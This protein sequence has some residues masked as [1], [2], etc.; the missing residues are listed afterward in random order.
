MSQV[1][2]Q[3]SSSDSEGSGLTFVRPLPREQSAQSD[4]QRNQPV[5]LRDQLEFA[6]R[7]FPL[8]VQGDSGSLPPVAGLELGHFVLEERIGRGGMGAVFRAI[9]KRLDRVVALKIL[10]SELSTDPEA[11]QRFQ[12][13]AR[14][15]AKLDHD[16]IARVHYIG[17]E[18]GLHFIA[19]EFV[20]G[21]NVR[22][23]IR[24]KG[25]L[26]PECVVNYTLQIAEALRQ[27]SA[28]GVVHRDIKPS[29]IIISS[30]GCAKLVDL[31]LARQQP[32]DQSQD[33]TVA[34]TALGTFDYIAPEQ[35]MDARNVDVRSDIYSLGC[36][37]Y[38]MLTGEPPYPKGTMFQKVMNHHGPTPPDAQ[39]KNQSVTVQL[40]R[41]IQKMMASNPDE[42]HATAESLINDLVQIAE[43]LGLAP[44]SP[45]TVVWTTPLFKA[46]NPYWDGSRTWMAVALVLLLLVYLVDSL[47]PTGTNSVATS[48]PSEGSGLEESPVGTPESHLPVGQEIAPD[49]IANSGVNNSPE[50][51]NH[52]T[53][54]NR[55]SQ[56][57][58]PTNLVSP[59]EFSG[60]KWS[61]GAMLV[62]NESFWSQLEQFGQSGV[63]GEGD[64]SSTSTTGMRKTGQ[65][66]ETGT[67]FD[68]RDD[69]RP[70]YVAQSKSG[71][72]VNVAKL[73]EAFALA[74][75]NT[76]IE[77]QS[78][79]VL[80]LQKKPVQFAGKRV[81]L[82]AAENF[83]P[84]VRFDLAEEFNRYRPL[85]STASVFEIGHGGALEIYDVDLELIVDSQTTVD[86]WSIVSLSPGAEFVAGGSSFTLNN[87]EQI[88]SS[89]V[90]IPESESTDNPNFMPERMSERTTTIRIRDSICRGQ[91]DLVKQL[92]LHP[93]DVRVEE[94]ALA[95]SGAVHR[96]DGSNSMVTNMGTEAEPSTSL[97]LNHVTALTGD[98][99]LSAT[100]GDHGNLEMMTIDVRGSVIRVN[101]SEHSLVDVSGHLDAD[102]LIEK[103]QWRSQSDRSFVQSSG[104]IFSVESSLRREPQVVSQR[105]LG[106]TLEQLTDLNMF[107]RIPVSISLLHTVQPVAFHLQGD[108]DG[109]TNPALK[110]GNDGRDA[111]VDWTRSKLPKTLPL[112]LDG[113]SDVQFI[114]DEL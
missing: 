20:T 104:P 6:S 18:N 22:E 56:V 76:V 98:G 78:D 67:S 4:G 21:T 111:G 92:D 12:N 10:S 35:A 9:D 34:G 100:T 113:I 77:I 65:S 30:T 108:E 27:T 16:N 106:A 48:H 62:N 66:D 101:R 55:D 39:L 63:S 26:D 69:S 68:V 86:E 31:G 105:G 72:A 49:H 52:D 24:Q 28:V 90:F 14:A 80:S 85:A 70:F 102:L 23:F 33:L 60:M 41:V 74:V 50:N 75:D 107:E 43:S 32:V 5:N 99:L 37:M 1:S 57:E 45:E 38:H 7:L 64:S 53:E 103:I 13:E 51:T 71:E 89:F 61:Q 42:R 19:F 95:I 87:P 59:T 8:H 58:D 29:N 2:A 88:S 94:S 79:G 112:P 83:H 110:A 73:S 25:K 96:L 54:A 36:T 11:V 93:L 44:T 109:F 82:R 15:A 3:Q 17:E 84:V 47:Q 81:I 91:M 40:S 97:V 114:E 46:R